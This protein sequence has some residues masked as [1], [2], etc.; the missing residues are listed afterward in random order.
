MRRH[1]RANRL[2]GHRRPSHGARRACLLATVGVLLASPATAQTVNDPG[3]QVEVVAR[4]LVQPT[5]MAFIGD[6]DI[7]VLQKANGQVRR[8]VGGVVQA[9]P[10]LDVA[11]DSASERGLLGIALDPDFAVNRRVFL[12]Y[13]ESATGTDTVG[14][15]PPLGNRVY[16]YTWDGTALVNPVLILDLPVLP[17]PNHNAGVLTF[18]PDGSLYAIIGDL[19][20]GGKLQ[21]N[22]FGADPDDTGVMFRVDTDGA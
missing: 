3:L 7:L 18:G 9:T 19:N 12:Y 2:V 20:H 6:D 11:V 17:G 13:T 16:R 15:P 1:N 5:T 10:M 8:I 4:G 22:V 14:S 21:N